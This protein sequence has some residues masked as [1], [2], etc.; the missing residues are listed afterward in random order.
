MDYTKND[1]STHLNT[2]RLENLFSQTEKMEGRSHALT[3]GTWQL[4]QKY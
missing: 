1:K 3:Q 4:C 2:D